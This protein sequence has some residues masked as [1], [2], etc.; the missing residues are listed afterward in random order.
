[1]EVR[2]LELL[3][4]LSV[5]GSVTAVAAATFR[6]PSAVSQQLRTA[7]R[8]LGVALVEPVSRG[9]RL[10]APGQ[11][12]ADGAD[13]VLRALAELQ[14]RLDAG[15]GRP[16]G[17]VAIGTLPSA[18][19][20]LLPE[21]VRRLRDTEIELDIDDFDLAEADYA[22]R[23]LDADVV[24]AHSLTGDV[25]AGAEALTARVLARE[26]I[27][28]ALPAEH[29][30]AAR[31]VLTPADLIGT[32]W[33]GVP[34][35]YPFDSILVA[36]ETVT[37]CVLPRSIRLRDNRLVES[38]VAAGQGLALLPRFTTRPR[39]GMAIRPLTGVPVVRSVV[40]VARPDRLARL[41][42]RHVVEELA[43]IGGDLSASSPEPAG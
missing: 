26:P 8:E 34:V 17:R 22:N 37:G 12:L 23:T 21:L 19:E 31:A 30:L 15:I 11:L 35:G 40:A 9:I 27:D 20:A 24:I 43:A 25:P 38:L 36:V 1:M 6:T 42:V 32:S 33:I 39:P 41:A 5:R 3:R 16:R 18:G 2:H 29:P 28:V 7:E 4:E 13:D 10:T 14:A